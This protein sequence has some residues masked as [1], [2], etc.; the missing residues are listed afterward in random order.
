[1]PSKK[2]RD[3][4]ACPHCKLTPDMSFPEYYYDPAWDINQNFPVEE[5]ARSHV[6]VTEGTPKEDTATFH[7]DRAFAESL[8]PLAKRGGQTHIIFSSLQPSAK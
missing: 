3:Q 2:Q 6:V 8:F 4:G 7:S 5:L 1:M